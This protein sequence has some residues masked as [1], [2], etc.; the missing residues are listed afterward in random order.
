VSEEL[1]K[2]TAAEVPAASERIDV[3][4]DEEAIKRGLWKAID[5]VGMAFFAKPACNTCNGQGQKVVVFQKT[6]RIMSLCYCTKRGV[7]KWVDHYRRRTIEKQVLAAES[8]TRAASPDA[9]VEAPAET[10][11]EATQE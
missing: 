7:E 2:E 11:A 1:R 5:D 4:V 9:S 10:P 8:E 3:V 6:N